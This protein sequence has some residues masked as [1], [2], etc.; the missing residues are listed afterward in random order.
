MTS[1][2]GKPNSKYCL[3]YHISKIS[4]IFSHKNCK[5]LNKKFV[6]ELVLHSTH[7]YVRLV[8]PTSYL[9]LNSPQLSKSKY[10]DLGLCLRSANEI[11]VLLCPTYMLTYL[12]VMKNIF[13]D[14]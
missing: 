13:W 3:N 14:H 1:L 4:D 12:H 9:F 10:S 2:N 8:Y 11:I 5:E 7:N 6:K